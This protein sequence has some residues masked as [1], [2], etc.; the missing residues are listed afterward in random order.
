MIVFSKIFKND[1]KKEVNRS[2]K[3]TLDRNEITMLV[4][5]ASSSY[6]QAIQIYGDDQDKSLCISCKLGMLN[7]GKF[8]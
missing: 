4:Q 7:E 2:K 6:Q 8:S 3:D 5:H 1:G